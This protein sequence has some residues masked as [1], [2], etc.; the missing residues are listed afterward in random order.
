MDPMIGHVYATPSCDSE[1]TVTQL[2]S[3]LKSYET[4][5][6]KWLAIPAT[7]TRG[8]TVIVQFDTSVWPAAIQFAIKRM[9]LHKVGVR[10]DLPVDLMTDGR[11]RLY[12]RPLKNRGTS[13]PVQSAGLATAAIETE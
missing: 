12:V 13:S 2:R 11:G 3:L 7:H 8:G 4:S 6:G 5:R 1:P 10:L 9:P